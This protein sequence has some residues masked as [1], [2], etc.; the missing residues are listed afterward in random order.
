MLHALLQIPDYEKLLGHPILGKSWEGFVLESILSSLPLNVHPFFYRTSAGA[1]IDLLLELGPGNRWG[2]EVK[3]GKV[4][5]IRKGF[6]IAC[7]DLGV[8]RKYAIYTGDDTFP[9]SNDTTVLSLPRFMA[10]LRAHAG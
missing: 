8:Q 3:A 5:N 9:A 2:I 6:H 7:Q 1:E 4:P 10:E